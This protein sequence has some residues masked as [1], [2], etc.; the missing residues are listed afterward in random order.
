MSG[1]GVAS[2]TAAIDRLWGQ[3]DVDAWFQG[4]SKVVLPWRRAPQRRGHRL[5]TPGEV[6]ALLDGGPYLGDLDPRLLLATQ[7]WVVRSHVE[8]YLTR[9]WERT[10]MTSADRTL[11]HNRYPLVHAD[12]AGRLVLLGGHHRAMAALLQ[13]RPLRARVVRPAGMDVTAVLPG[14]LVGSTATVRHVV[15]NPAEAPGLLDAGHTVLLKGLAAA[16]AALVALAFDREQIDD[17]LEMAAVGRT[18]GD[19]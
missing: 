1:L 15:A 6:A 7:T 14:L 4:A 17:R 18:R 10:G 8:Y 5:Y 13:G 12:E 2:A 9:A 19:R 16:E 11:A 3:G